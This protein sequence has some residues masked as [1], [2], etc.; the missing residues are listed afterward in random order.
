MQF[1]RSLSC[2]RCPRVWALRPPFSCSPPTMKPLL[3]PSLQALHSAHSPAPRHLR[4]APHLDW[5]PLCSPPFPERLEDALPLFRACSLSWT[6][7]HEARNL[8]P[9][10]TAIV[11]GQRTQEPP[12][13]TAATWA[14][15]GPSQQEQPASAS[16]CCFLRGSFLTHRP[17][18]CP[19]ANRPTQELD[20][21]RIT[22]L[23]IL[24][25][26]P[27][28]AYFTRPLGAP[29]EACT[30]YLSPPTHQGYPRSRLR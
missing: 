10:Q 24:G 13:R 23:V 8:D 22:V 21:A 30:S 17:G 1:G 29:L 26:Q 3:R 4:A 11:P 5:K 15:L 28:S 9:S 6:D 20:T 27:T 14:T 7:T 16:V 18:C 2:C 19:R 25:S 12:A